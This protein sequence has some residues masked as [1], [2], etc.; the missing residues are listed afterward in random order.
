MILLTVVSLAA[1]VAAGALVDCATPQ[2]SVIDEQA[3][4]LC[5]GLSDMGLVED[6]LVV[7]GIAL[8]GLLVVTIAWSSAF[9]RWK[10][11]RRVESAGS[12]VNNIHRLA[13][14][15]SDSRAME[16]DSTGIHEIWN[17]L[18]ELEKMMRSTSSSG[19]DIAPTWLRLLRSA[20]DMHNRGQLSTDDFKIMNTRLLDLVSEGSDWSRSA[21]VG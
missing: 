10:R 4:V 21:T 16:D 11:R 9:R 20:N 1:V 12:L 8:A 3:A 13:E 6:P 17:R 5:N 7:A 18:D 14:P 19:R 15:P 2:V